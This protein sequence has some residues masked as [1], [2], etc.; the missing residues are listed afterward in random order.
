M[1]RKSLIEKLTPEQEARFPEFVQKWTAYGLSTA[2][3]NRADAERAI[4]MMYK[5][6]NLKPPTVVWC[7]SPMGNALTRALVVNSK[8]A[9]V[10]AS[11]WDSVWASVRA[12]VRASVG[13]SVW[14][15]VWDSDVTRCSFGT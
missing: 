13:A 15:S 2:P 1:P 12:S 11:V 10:W 3:A 8:N 5:R 9:S 4:A 7:G 14:D 6:A